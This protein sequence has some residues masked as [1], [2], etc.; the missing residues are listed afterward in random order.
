MNIKTAT[1][2]ALIGQVAGY[3]LSMST[4]TMHG[5]MSMVC[6]AQSALYNIPMIIFLFVLYRKQQ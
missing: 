6:I 1:L 4:M 3:A 2:I 5:A